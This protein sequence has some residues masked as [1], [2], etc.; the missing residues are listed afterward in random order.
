[1]AL[2]CVTAVGTSLKPGETEAADLLLGLAAA[3]WRTG[4]HDLGVEKYRTAVRIRWRYANASE[5]QESASPAAEKE[6][7]LEVL[8][9]P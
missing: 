1:V 6:P 7:L 2:T 9:E 4:Q 8:K 3:A 5:L